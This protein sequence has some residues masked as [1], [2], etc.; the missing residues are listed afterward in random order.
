MLV[1]FN[2]KFTKT[3]E[4]PGKLYLIHPETHLS[5]GTYLPKGPIS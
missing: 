1:L 4:T 2:R 5:S 3:M